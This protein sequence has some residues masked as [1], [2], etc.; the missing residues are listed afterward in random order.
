MRSGER[1]PKCLAGRMVVYSVRTNGF[2]RLRFL[3]CSAKCGHTGREA[4]ALDDLGRAVIL[5]SRAR[6]STETPSRSTTPQL[7]F[8]ETTLVD[9]LPKPTESTQ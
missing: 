2:S 1:C 8:S 5:P 9:Q 3:R 6:S 4:V 7:P